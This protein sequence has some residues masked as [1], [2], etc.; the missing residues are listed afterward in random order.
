MNRLEG[1]VV[2]VSGAGRGI[3][4]ALA[5]AFAAQ[6][7]AVAANDITPVHLDK[8]ID[9]IKAR[10]GVAQ[11]YIFDIAKKMPVFSMV[12]QVISD[13]GRIDILVNNAAVRP[14]A[15]ILEMRD[16]DWQRSLDVNLSGPFYCMQAVGKIMQ[17]QGG[18]SIINL[19]ADINGA[20]AGKPQAAFI[21]SKAGLIG[22]TRAAAKELAPYNVRVNAICPG[23]ATAQ[24]AQNREQP[25]VD[26]TPEVV[27]L[28]LMLCGPEAAAISGQIFHINP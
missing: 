24:G 22:L 19:A 26:N 14:G 7:A 27:A 3:G 28:A 25:Q 23:E 1:K 6:G 21:A 13:F 2:L 11:E 16:W 18:G 15:P 8:T 12:N 20:L 5:Q 10:G 17:E 4:R 9:N